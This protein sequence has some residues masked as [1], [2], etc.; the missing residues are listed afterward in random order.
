MKLNHIMALPPD[1][2]SETVATG[3]QHLDHLIG[4]LRMGHLCTV[5]ARLG[6][7][8]ICEW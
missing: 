5:A 4:G 7:G 3:F 2:K 1:K 8:G 6:F